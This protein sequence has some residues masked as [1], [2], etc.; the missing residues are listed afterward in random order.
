MLYIH[1]FFHL[2]AAVIIGFLIIDFLT[3]C[4]VRQVYQFLYKINYKLGGWICFFDLDGLKKINDEKGHQEGD[5]ILRKV[6]K[7]M[8]TASFFRAFRYGGDE[9]VILSFSKN[10]EKTEKVIKKIK[11][12]L[13]ELEFSYGI[14]KTE[15]EADRKMYRMKKLHKGRRC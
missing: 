4:W 7:A 3:F 15:S 10:K 1:W 11:K 2:A 13:E 6:G 9:F 5:K 12:N 14:G 8:V